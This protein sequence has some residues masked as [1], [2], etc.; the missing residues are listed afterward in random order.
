[1]YPLDG[2]R[3]IVNIL[4]LYEGLQIIF[5]DLREVVLEFRATMIFL[6]LLPARRALMEDVFDINGRHR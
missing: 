6:N 1:V 3:N 5:Q 4:G 2:K